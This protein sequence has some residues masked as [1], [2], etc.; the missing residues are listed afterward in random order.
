MASL[1]SST[2]LKRSSR[3]AQALKRGCGL[4]YLVKW[5]DYSNAASEQSWLPAKTPRQRS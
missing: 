2:K 5:K 1:D 3:Q 4:Q